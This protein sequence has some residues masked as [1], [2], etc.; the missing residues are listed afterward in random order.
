MKSRFSS[1]AMVMLLSIAAAALT[2]G[3]T[4]PTWVRA[5]LETTMGATTIDVA[6]SD[7]APAVSSLALVVLAASIAVR[8]AGPKIRWV[9]CCIMAF[10]G[11]GMAASIVQVATNPQAATLTEVGKATGQ[12][13]A[14]GS[15]ALTFWPWV[16]LFFAVVIVLN[17]IVTAMASRHWPTRRKYE[18]SNTLVHEDMDEIDTWDSFTAGEDPTDRGSVAR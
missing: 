9:I 7:A 10:A 11:A 18:R 17:S 5:S 13:G 6:G 8:I 4:L 16:A 15:F 1:P 12:T 14:G 2:F 3:T